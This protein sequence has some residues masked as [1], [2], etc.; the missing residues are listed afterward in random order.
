M[1]QIYLKSFYWSYIF[2]H[3]YVLIQCLFNLNQR[4]N[5]FSN[6]DTNFFTI[7][8][9]FIWLTSDAINNFVRQVATKVVEIG[10]GSIF[11][12]K[13]WYPITYVSGSFF[14]QWI[15]HTCMIAMR[16]IFLLSHINKFWQKYIKQL[17][18][19]M[20]F[21]ILKTFKCGT[22]LKVYGDWM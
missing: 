19:K 1:C 7:N 11:S 17:R 14:I 22:E 13:G 10:G 3:F 21:C 8:P 12:K 6:N 4:K 16:Y 18:R 20:R 2:F 15:M 9:L 5:D